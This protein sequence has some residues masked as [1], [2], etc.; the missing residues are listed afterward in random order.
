MPV[1]A[2]VLDAL[3]DLVHGLREAQ[4]ARGGLAAVVDGGMS[5]R[6]AAKRFGIAPSTAIKRV[7][8]RQRPENE[9]RAAPDP[10]TAETAVR[11]VR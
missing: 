4:R 2:A 3:D 5:R 7:H 11:E 10:E 1:P 8:T 9:G 6:S